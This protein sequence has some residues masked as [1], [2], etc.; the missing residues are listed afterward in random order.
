VFVRA[1]IFYG[2]LA[3]LQRKINLKMDAFIVFEC[4]AERLF[5]K[6][7]DVI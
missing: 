6:I 2:Q 3:F 7:K 1:F 4:E 5:E